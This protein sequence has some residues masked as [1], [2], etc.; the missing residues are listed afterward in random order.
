MNV[1]LVVGLIFLLKKFHFWFSAIFCLLRIFLI[2]SRNHLL[3]FSGP[4]PGFKNNYPNNQQNSIFQNV[5]ANN[6]QQNSSQA[7]NSANFQNTNNNSF[8]QRGGSRGGYRFGYGNQSHHGG[9]IIRKEPENEKEAEHLDL[10][11]DADDGMRQLKE[12]CDLFI[13]NIKFL[14]KYVYFFFQN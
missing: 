7:N 1:V 8:H 14:Y 12:C 2:F 5:H 11:D 13:K 6:F 3:S 4:I 10:E 9:T